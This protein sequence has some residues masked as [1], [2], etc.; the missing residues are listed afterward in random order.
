M[1][2]RVLGNNV[3]WWMI[4]L[5]Y[6]QIESFCCTP[7]TN[8]II[9]QLYLHFF[10]QKDHV[11]DG[12][13]SLV[14]VLS[15]LWVISPSPFHLLKSYWFISDHLS[16]CLGSIQNSTTNDIQ[17]RHP[18]STIC[19]VFL[20]NSYLLGSC[21]FYVTMNLLHSMLPSQFHK[22]YTYK[23]ISMML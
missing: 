3:W 6:I 14:L 18:P 23:G 17:H 2:G 16:F 1:E 10:F 13:S 21:L 20:Y 22:W 15:F 9:H 7:E 12:F 4:I 19:S 8:N 5:Q 11:H